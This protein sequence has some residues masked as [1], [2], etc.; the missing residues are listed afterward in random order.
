MGI[1]E[2]QNDEW[3]QFKI[4]YKHND[5]WKNAAIV[6]TKNEQYAIAFG[7]NQGRSN[8]KVRSDDI[9]VYNVKNKTLRKSMVICPKKAYYTAAMIR[10]TY[11]DELIVFGFVNQ[12]FAS[13]E[14]ENMQ[15][16][17]SG[18]MQFLCQW[19]SNEYIHLIIPYSCQHWR[20][21]VDL[22]L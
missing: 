15:Q 20:I 6:S 10:D 9:F 5:I 7:G 21:S 13:Q 17:S 18:F 14:F 22:I 3:T 11:R 1:Y 2:Y 8:S 4:D 19:V 12:C 16:F